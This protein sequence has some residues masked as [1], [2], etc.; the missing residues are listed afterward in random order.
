[1]LKKWFWIQLKE[2][3]D[4]D[5]SEDESE[6]EYYKKDFQNKDFFAD[7]VYMCRLIKFHVYL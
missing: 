6:D 7:V 2:D 4:K 5:K 3:E 1:M